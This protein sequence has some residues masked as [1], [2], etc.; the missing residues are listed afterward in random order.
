M[1]KHKNCHTEI[2]SWDQVRKSIK[3]V[4]PELV[5]HVD[6]LNPDPSLKMYR[7]RYSYGSDILKN[8]VLHVPIDGELLPITDVQ[9]DA[10]IRQGLAYAK[11]VPIGV[12]IN[13]GIELYL[14]SDDHMIPVV[15]M[16]KGTVFALTV[17]L[18]EDSAYSRGALFDIS[19]GARSI[20]MLPKITNSQ[21]FNR[22][23]SDFDLSSAV[24]DRLYGHFELFRDI[25][26]HSHNLVEKPWTTEVIYFSG[27]WLENTVDFKWRSL[28]YFLLQK[29][30][31]STGYWR[32]QLVSDFI[33]S[34][35]QRQRG[36]KPDPYL[37][38]TMKHLFAIGMGAFPGYGIACDDECAP[39][40]FLQKVF[41]DIYRLN[42]APVIMQPFNLK[43]SEMDRQLYYSLNV[44]SLR[45]FSPK[46]K[47]LASKISDMRDLKRIVR[48]ISQEIEKNI[49]NISGG[50]SSIY[51]LI[52]DIDFE[53]YHTEKDP[54]NELRPAKELIDDD[55]HLAQVIAESKRDIFNQNCAFLKG[56]IGVRQ[57]SS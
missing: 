42:S 18:E 48:M 6:I 27:D 2:L 29:A 12:V 45:A 53:F 55:Q 20:F 23:S 44:P 51:S 11:T 19:A 41:A 15:M 36:M 8:G 49:F 35:S 25:Y 4:N 57:K 28:R 16:R 52:Q 5:E 50:Q 54:Y 30:W 24:P 26:Q 13:Q 40:S 14:N 9:V 32:E 10:Q 56:C 38:D 17:A 21:G 43:P 33:I 34:V 1:S 39:I 46:G 47:K 31:N 22:L 37:I 3:Q 7:A